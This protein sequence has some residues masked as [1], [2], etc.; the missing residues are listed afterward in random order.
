MTVLTSAAVGGFVTSSS[1]LEGLTCLSE[2]VIFA[3]LPKRVQE[4]VYNVGLLAV[5]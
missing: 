5:I 3:P 4:V 1:V 2:S